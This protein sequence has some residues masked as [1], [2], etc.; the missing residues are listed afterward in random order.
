MNGVTPLHI[1][2]KTW[3]L[4]T[5]IVQLIS[6]K[7]CNPNALNKEGDTPLHIAVRDNRAYTWIPQLLSNK[8]MQ[9]KYL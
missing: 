2:V 8:A 6:C 7:E 1:A 4:N 9:S 3:T 5:P